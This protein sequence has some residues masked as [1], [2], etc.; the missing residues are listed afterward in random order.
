M[1][2]YLI[3]TTELLKK[4]VSDVLYCTFLQYRRHVG[5]VVF[6]WI[7]SVNYTACR[8]AVYMPPR[9]FQSWHYDN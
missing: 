3:W 1:S 5:C 9:D 7:L 4:I 6:A 8:C 2:I